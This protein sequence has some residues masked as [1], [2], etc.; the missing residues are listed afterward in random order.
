MEFT[1]FFTAGLDANT[2]GRR[3]RGS[4]DSKWPIACAS[5]GSNASEEAH[6]TSDNSL[7][8]FDE[9]EF[10]STDFEGEESYGE[11]E[12]Y[13]VDDSPDDDDDD[14]IFKP[15]ENA[16]VADVDYVVE[17]EEEDEDEDD[18]SDD[19]DTSSSNTNEMSF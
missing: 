18:D 10:E 1:L 15:D 2:E 19:G 7:D 8:E 9:F 5:I 14:T 6:S 4:R 17:E 11:H 16:D 12:L 3:R 13:E